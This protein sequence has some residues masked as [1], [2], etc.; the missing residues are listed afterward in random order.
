MAQITRYPMLAH[1]R[2]EP[3]QYILH[4]S[5]GRITR[6]GPGAAPQF[7]LDKSPAAV[8]APRAPGVAGG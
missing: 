2:G 4:Y 8:R 1:L 7:D 5:S 3:N 6:E